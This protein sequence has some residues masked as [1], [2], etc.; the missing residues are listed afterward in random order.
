M[1]FSLLRVPDRVPT[2]DPTAAGADDTAA[3]VRA[4]TPRLPLVEDPMFRPFFDAYLVG[5]SRRD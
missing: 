2:P 1:L 3:D 5:R 4:R